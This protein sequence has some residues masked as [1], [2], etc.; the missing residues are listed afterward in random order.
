M[1][2]RS[3][4]DWPD[5]RQNSGFDRLAQSVFGKRH[6]K[7]MKGQLAATEN[8]FRG[9]GANLSLHSARHHGGDLPAK[10]TSS[11]PITFLAIST[12]DD[13]EEEEEEG[14]P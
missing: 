4:A 7:S 11:H 13:K 6:E 5:Q 2:A 14:P 9:R 1:Q 12:R 10:V 8:Q 3:N